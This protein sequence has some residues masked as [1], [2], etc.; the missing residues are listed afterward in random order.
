MET[1]IIWGSL[2]QHVKDAYDKALKKNK[3]WTY[4]WTQVDIIIHIHITQAELGSGCVD[5]QD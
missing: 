3:T 5:S 4:V 2:Y 1:I